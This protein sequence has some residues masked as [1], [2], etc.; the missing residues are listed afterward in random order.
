MEKIDDM[1]SYPRHTST[2]YNEDLEA[3]VEVGTDYQTH[4]QEQWDGV[5]DVG[6]RYKGQNMLVTIEKMEVL[7][8]RAQL[9]K[10][11][12][13]AKSGKDKDKDK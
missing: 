8:L 6:C 10:Q 5:E 12:N 2:H 9:D 7:S 3:L 13:K 4:K 1:V 11:V